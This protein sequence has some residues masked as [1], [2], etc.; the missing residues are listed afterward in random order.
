MDGQRK[1][2]SETPEKQ[3]VISRKNENTQQVDADNTYEPKCLKCGAT[4]RADQLFCPKC[5]TKVVVKKRKMSKKVKRTIIGSVTGIIA[6]ACVLVVALYI[7]PQYI[8]PQINL[9]KA[10][11]AFNAQDYAGAIDYYEK[12]GLQNDVENVNQY[13]YAIAMTQFAAN[14][15]KSAAQTFGKAGGI[16]ESDAK[17]F[18]CGIALKDAKD[19]AS[20][21]DC[22]ALISTDE[23]D[24]NRAYCE[25][26]VAYSQK[27]YSVAKAK[28]RKAGDYPEASTY[29]TACSLMEAEELLKTGHLNEAK[30]AFEKLPQEFSFD[31]ISVSDRVRTIN[32]AGAFATVCGEWSPTKNYIE[33]RNVYKRNGSWDS[34]YI[35]ETLSDQSLEITCYLNS[36]GTVTIKGSVS[37]YR[38][39]DYSSL[40][41]YCEAT[42]T[43]ENFT[44]SNLKSIPSSYNIDSNT[45]L[46]Y[47]NGNFSLEYSMRDNYST[48]FY[49]LYNS[50]IT[51]GSKTTSY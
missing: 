24:V 13:T 51:F 16:L 27:D 46:K 20:A 49:N 22:F 5:G 21:V 18:E 31:N 9:S 19:Y 10:E 50:S 39:T 34:W 15:Y 1:T 7:F 41:A 42:K 44:I 6:I 30:T 40:S 3:E 28:F 36:D 45:T 48:Y 25:G 37:F 26:M 29:V 38:F 2:T 8:E 33:S 11:S 12:S 35:D 32:N 43:T 47:S 14:D 23:A 17:I 4:L